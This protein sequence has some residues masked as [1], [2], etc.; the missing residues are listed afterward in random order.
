MTKKDYVALAKIIKESTINWELN[1]ERFRTMLV[2]YLQRNN[3]RFNTRKFLEA[4]G[5]QE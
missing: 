2:E 4:C 3:A 1:E 5:W